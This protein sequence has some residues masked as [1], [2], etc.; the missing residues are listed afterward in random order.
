MIGLPVFAHSDDLKARPL[1]YR[2]RE[3]SVVCF[4]PAGTKASLDTVISIAVEEPLHVG[5][6]IEGEL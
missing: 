6:V 1:R 3:P 5:E 2:P 4:Q